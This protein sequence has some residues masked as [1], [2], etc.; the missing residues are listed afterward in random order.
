MPSKRREQKGKKFGW[1]GERVAVGRRP[2]LPREELLFLANE[3]DLSQFADNYIPQIPPRFVLTFL[4][5]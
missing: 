4:V 2:L 5:Y 1:K 3:L